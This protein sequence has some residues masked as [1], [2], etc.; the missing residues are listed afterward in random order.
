LI[1]VGERV[2]CK[3]QKTK[4]LLFLNIR[5]DVFD[6][7]VDLIVRQTVF[8]GG[9]AFVGNAVF[10]VIEVFRVRHLFHLVARQV[11]D[12]DGFAFDFLFAARAVRFVAVGAI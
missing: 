1:V 7:G 12:V 5:A 8:E 11:I 4:R 6:D 10:N 9:H 2:I 3:L